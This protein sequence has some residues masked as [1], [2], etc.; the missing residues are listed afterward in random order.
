MDARMERRCWTGAA[1][2][3]IFDVIDVVGRG[4]ARRS[5]VFVGTL[6][7]GVVNVLGATGALNALKPSLTEAW[8]RVSLAITGCSVEVDSLRATESAGAAFIRI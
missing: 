4:M 6:A 7:V 3:P 8:E 5:G 2:S 1:L